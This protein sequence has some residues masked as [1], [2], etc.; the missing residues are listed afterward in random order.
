MS[1]P[2]HETPQTPQDL[3]RVQTPITQTGTSQPVAL[4]ARGTIAVRSAANPEDRPIWPG[5]AGPSQ[6]TPPRAPR[7]IRRTTTLDITFPS[8][9]VLVLHGVGRDLL[10]NLTDY[11]DSSDSSIEAIVLDQTEA[12]IEVDH[13]ARLVSTIEIPGADEGQHEAAQQLIGV[14]ATGKLR[15]MLGVY[16][17]EEVSSGS[18]LAQILD[19]VP[20]ATLIA[21]SALFRQGLIEPSPS[22]EKR[23]PQVDVCTGW[24]SGGVMAQ[25]IIE[26]DVPYMGEGPLAPTLLSDTDPLAWH[27]FPPLSLGAMRRHRRLDITHLD[28]GIDSSDGYALDIFFRD[29]FVEPDGR[30]SVVHEYAITGTLD[31]QGTITAMIATPH[32]I[33]GPECPGAAASAQ[34]VIGLPLSEV[35]AH[36]TA[37]FSGISTCTHLNDMLRSLGAMSTVFTQLR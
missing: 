11:S 28:A 27:E 15:K 5:T 37:E 8:L 7:S 33:P 1:T 21:G 16:L 14:P 24:K 10:T 20:A 4:T 3:P 23:R 18:L 6:G 13:Y 34:R 29:S 2:P 35:R 25:A 9:G 32:V 30:Q 12:T 19:D 31:S 26:D 36:V 17:P 22:S